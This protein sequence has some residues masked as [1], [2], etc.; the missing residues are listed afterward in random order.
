MNGLTLVHCAGASYHGLFFYF[1]LVLFNCLTLNKSFEM[2]WALACSST[3]PKRK[4]GWRQTSSWWWKSLNQFFILL[5]VKVVLCVPC[6]DV[7]SLHL[8]LYVI[9]NSYSTNWFGGDWSCSRFLL[10]QSW[11]IP[12]SYFICLYIFFNR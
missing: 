11:R 5:W 12:S 4:K 8:I 6:I 10:L 7:I 3:K 1:I 9:L 2:H